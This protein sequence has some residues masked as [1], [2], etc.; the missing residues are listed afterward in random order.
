MIREA[1]IVAGGRTAI[2]R[3]HK[4][5]LRQIRTDDLAGR[6]IQHLLLQHQDMLDP[7]QIE[8][9]VMGCAYPE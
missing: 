5:S 2:G 6:V 8:D 1:V 3:A 9:V 4:G 7:S